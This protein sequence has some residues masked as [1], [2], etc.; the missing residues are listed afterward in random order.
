[1]E[2]EL[3]SGLIGVGVVFGGL[4][5]LVGMIAADC[6]ASAEGL[7]GWTGPAAIAG[8]GAAGVIARRRSR[9]GDRQ[10]VRTAH[11]DQHIDQWAEWLAQFDTYELREAVQ[12]MCDPATWVRI[13][14]GR[15]RTEHDAGAWPVVTAAKN[16]PIGVMVAMQLPHGHDRDHYADRLD[17]IQTALDMG[18][19]RIVSKHG[20]EMLMELRV[21]DPCKQV[22]HSEL[23]DAVE[24]V[25]PDG[26]PHTVYLLR[27]PVDGL[28]VY[29]NIPFG[30][31]EYG[32]LLT[33]NLVED[34]HLGMGGTT[35][36]GKSIGLNNILAAAMLM[37]DCKVV[38]IDPNGAA[39][40]PWKR[41]AHMVCDTRDA[42]KAIEV[43]K[44]VVAEME[45]RQALFEE[46][47][48]DKLTEFSADFPLWLVA[49]D[50]ASN[51][52]DSKE[53]GELMEKVSAQCAKYGIK[54]IIIAQKMVGENVPTGARAQL[55]GRVTFRVND[56]ADYRALFAN[57]PQFAEDIMLKSRTPQGVGIASLPCHED[58]VRFRS[59]YLP[60]KACFAIGKAIVAAR[61]P[62]RPAS[63]PALPPGQSDSNASAITIDAGPAPEPVHRK[64]DPR[65]TTPPP[66]RKPQA[67]RPA[68]VLPFTRA[69]H[70]RQ[71]EATPSQPD[72]TPTGD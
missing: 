59:L 3:D 26:T 8:I 5:G 11:M 71:A 42:D 66:T 69:A 61:G 38:L 53:F 39:S 47:E 55:S 16:T 30:I 67:K 60:T 51:F 72:P 29:D 41:C 15:A 44:E 32:D 25:L 65:A 35:R 13:G 57:A 12:R 24:T 52:K 2:Q 50:E 14:L 43:L 64:A 70:S 23:V 46:Y 7:P 18:D 37:R 45:R 36:A 49:I 28:S 48:V 20:N 21:N 10:A 1:M 22:R 31:T 34:D 6:V 54:L 33:V 19:I 40:G 68:T 62:A 27:V 56:P 63:A 58:P 9:K 17:K 4:T